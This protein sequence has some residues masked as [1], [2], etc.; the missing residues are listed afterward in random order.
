MFKSGKDIVH[1]LVVLFIAT[2][3]HIT[4]AEASMSIP[5]HKEEPSKPRLVVNI[6]VG[7]LRASDLERYKDNFTEGGF[8]RLMREGAY[9]TNAEYGYL[10]TSTAAG[11][12][13][14]STG[15]QP[16]V[17]G[18]VGDRWWNYVDSSNVELI[19]DSKSHSVEFSTGSGNYSPRLL[20]APT[21]GDML[22]NADE[23][24]HQYTIAVDAHSA[25]VLNGKRGVAFWAE[26]N[27]T[28]W[29][30]SSFYR[31]SLPEW[32]TNYNRHDTN[33]F[34]ALTRWTPLYDAA[35]YLN[36]EIAVVEGITNKSTSLISEVNLRLASTPYGRMRYTPAGNT[37]LF[38]FAS[39]MVA[40]E[41]LGQ[42]TSP[43]ILNICLDPAR[44]IAQTYGPES[45]EYEDMLY[46]LDK[47][48]EEFLRFIYA[49]VE[50]PQ[51]IL[52]VL[53]ADHGT[54]PS[55]N[56]AGKNDKER[57]NT[58]QME[59]I[60]NAFLGAKYGSDSYVLGYANNAIYL[61]HTLI[62]SKKLS[63][64]ALRE[65]V[66]VFMLQLRGVA[67]AVSTSSLR[68]TSFESGRNH[69][70]QQGFYPSRSGDVV[71]DFMPEW[72]VEDSE[73]RSA[74]MAGYRYD[75]EVPLLIYGGGIAAQRIER[76][77][78][79]S[80]VAPTI[81]HILDIESPWGSEQEAIKE[82]TTEVSK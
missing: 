8:K 21:I 13:T 29:T 37:M 41:K 20:I 3:A 14:I 67:T 4:V 52:V 58:R 53:S 5:A 9:F 71:I 65:E 30:T 49:Q 43:D 39:S 66:A 69:L 73:Y 36:S 16:S 72:I 19:K 59:V 6:I 81:A 17:H 24:S 22:L 78:D 63:I 2:V 1:K 12:A 75:R 32:I 80:E 61:N 64:D 33:N 54:S 34:Y 35:K 25:I 28:H 26:S 38:E 50:S 82:I 56:P 68:N 10:H 42:D 27:Q 7:S 79:I 62:N 76:K 47:D 74:S 15:A 11:L 48:L 23:Q 60:V 57:F 70:M 18:I 77:V 44:Y 55:Y 31:T 51:S 45:I 40:L 46:R